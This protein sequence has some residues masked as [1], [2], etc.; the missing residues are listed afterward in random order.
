M[1]VNR[2]ILLEKYLIRVFC[3]NSHIVI[4]YAAQGQCMIRAIDQGHK[5]SH[6]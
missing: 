2:N 3:I 1:F 4:V 6:G 5:Q